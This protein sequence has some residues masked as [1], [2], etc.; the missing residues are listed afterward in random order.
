MVKRK[1]CVFISGKGSNLEN[2]IKKSRDYNFPINISL[3]ISNNKK[4]EG[5]KICKNEFYSFFIFNEK[6]DFFDYQVLNILKYYNVN[7]ICLAD[8][9]V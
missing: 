5:I 2:L 6:V 3:V 4:A 1:A 7:L 9:C 8:I